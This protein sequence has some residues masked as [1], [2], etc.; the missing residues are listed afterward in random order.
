LLK[1]RNRTSPS[2]WEK[3]AGR[4]CYDLI[5]AKGAR[6]LRHGDSRGCIFLLKGGESGH[7]SL[8]RGGGKR[9]TGEVVC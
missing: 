2:L 9:L 7:L 3:G 5:S 6:L 4:F 8:Y 1:H